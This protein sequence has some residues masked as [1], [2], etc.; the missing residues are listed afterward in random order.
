MRLFL[1]TQNRCPFTCYTLFFA[2]FACSNT[3][4]SAAHRAALPFGK[5]S[6]A[7]AKGAGV[8]GIRKE[9]ADDS[10]CRFFIGKDHSLV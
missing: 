2:P 1:I 4:G 10:V 7:E 9:A 5:D 3:N 6:C 8:N